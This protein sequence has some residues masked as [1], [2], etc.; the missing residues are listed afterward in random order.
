MNLGKFKEL[1]IIGILR[2]INNKDIQPLIDCVINSGLTTLEI[3]MNTSGAG[4]L[5]KEMVK[6][7]SGRLVIGAG[8]VLNM[9]ELGIALESG[10]TF[11]VMPIYIKEIVNYC[12]NN[13]IP[14]F[15][16]ALTPTE[17]YDAW[18][19]GASMVKVFPSSVFGPK[20]FQEIKAPL[21]SIDLLACGG[22]SPDSIGEYFSFGATGVAFGA[23]IFKLEWIN[24]NM[25]KKISDQIKKLI[26]AYFN[27][28][29]IEMMN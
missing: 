21:N 19:G 6:Y 27:W 2:G 23:S 1:P 7:S 8:T 5:I 25:Y 10:A 20:Y 29:N 13:N 3:T 24:N 28:K 4:K 11:I 12:V 16:G 26:Q 22:V 17:I 18:S 14:V 15:P 9:N